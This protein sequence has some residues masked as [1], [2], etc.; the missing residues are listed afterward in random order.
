MEESCCYPPWQ[1]HPRY[2]HYCQPHPS[3][4]LTDRY[5]GYQWA[6]TII[7]GDNWIIADKRGG[8]GEPLLG[9]SWR[10]RH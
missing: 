9:E 10:D 8:F 7:C 2:P 3:S 4:L 6:L 5:Y 1:T